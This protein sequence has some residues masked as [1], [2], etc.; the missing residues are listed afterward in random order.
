MGIWYIIGC[1]NYGNLSSSAATQK[2]FDLEHGAVV[3]LRSLG[4]PSIQTLLIL[5]PTVDDLLRVFW[6]LMV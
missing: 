4:A 5:G 3:R 2:S 6:S 1:L